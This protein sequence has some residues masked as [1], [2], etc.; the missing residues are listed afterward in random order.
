[1]RKR[2]WVILGII[3][4]I[5][6]ISVMAYCVFSIGKIDVNTTV[7]I[8]VLSQEEKNEIIALSGIK[9]GKNIFAIDEDIAIENIEKSLPTLKVISIERTFPNGVYIYVTKRTPV[10]YLALS[11]GEYAILDRELKIISIQNSYDAQ[12]TQLVGV[13]A[14]NIE[15]GNILPNSQILAKIIKGAEQSK[16]R[17]VNAR[18]C[19]FYRKVEVDSSYVY[20]TS[21]TGV[22][23]QLPI[24]SNIDMSVI[25]SYGYYIGDENGFEGLSEKGKSEGYVYLDKHGWSWKENL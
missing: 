8:A 19:A 5:A 13:K 18:F 23:F 3:V 17:F 21:N 2:L 1:M 11:G 6:V 22:I 12:L 20:L 14:E 10:F 4:G 16:G 25:G 24:S 7:D 15:V 9:K